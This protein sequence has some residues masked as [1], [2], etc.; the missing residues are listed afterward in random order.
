MR[1]FPRCACDDLHWFRL[2]YDLPAALWLQQCGLQ[3]PDCGLLF[4]VGH[5]HAGFLPWYAR[6]QDPYRGGK[7][8]AKHACMKYEYTQKQHNEKAEKTT[9]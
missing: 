5:T 4:T 2:P 7:V 8:C 3:L 6:R 9:I 1:R